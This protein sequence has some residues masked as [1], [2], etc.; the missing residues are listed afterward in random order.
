MTLGIKNANIAI[1]TVKPLEQVTI[2]F[3]VKGMYDVPGGVTFAEF[4]SEL[5]GGGTSRIRF[6]AMLR[7]RSTRTR[8]FGRSSTSQRLLVRMSRAV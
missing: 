5:A 4:F 8:R 6:L 7:S 1:G 3:D 2:S